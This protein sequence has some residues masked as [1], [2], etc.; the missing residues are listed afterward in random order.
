MKIAQNDLPWTC[1][2]IHLCNEETK[3]HK[4][5]DVRRV[6]DMDSLNTVGKIGLRHL[7]PFIP[8]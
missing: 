8:Q 4:I 3:K 5:P 1:T 7:K 6:D 2:L